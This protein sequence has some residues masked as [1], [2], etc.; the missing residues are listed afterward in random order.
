MSALK[1]CHTNKALVELERFKSSVDFERLW[2]KRFENIII[3]IFTGGGE[4]E[5][6]SYVGEMCVGSNTLAAAQWGRAFGAEESCAL[7]A[8][9]TSRRVQRANAKRWELHAHEQRPSTDHAPHEPLQARPPGSQKSHDSLAQSFP[10]LSC[11]FTSLWM[12]FV[13][14]QK[15]FYPEL[16]L[17]KFLAPVQE[18]MCENHD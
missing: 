13:K 9:W 17:G 15:P 11:W 3:L 4:L 6:H 7:E 10:S 8:E 12:F 16:L 18:S 1:E 2:F 5:Q 14:A